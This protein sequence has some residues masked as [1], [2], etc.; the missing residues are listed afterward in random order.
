MPP[1]SE[2]T[3]KQPPIFHRLATFAGLAVCLVVGLFLGWAKDTFYHP[4]H[5][6]FK[7][8]LQYAHGDR[9]TQDYSKAREFYQKAADQGSVAAMYN[10]ALL[11]EQGRGGPEDYVKADEW[12][13][14]GADRGDADSMNRLGILYEE[15]KGVTQD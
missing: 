13:Q 1:E 6:W 11:Y 9:V 14:K 3:N 12:Y 15:G 4:S 10:L 2:P 7:M 5:T 8:G